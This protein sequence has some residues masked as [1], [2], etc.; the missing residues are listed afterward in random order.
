MTST[1]LQ[2]QTVVV[3]G[4]SSG[5]GLETARQANAAGA[6]VVVSGRDPERLEQAAHEIGALSTATFDATD[7]EQLERFFSGLPT[8]VDHVMV[9]AGGSYYA[10]LPDMNLAEVRRALEEHVLLTLSVARCSIGK[11]RPG[12]SLTFMTGT[13]ARHPVAGLAIAGVL[14]A[15]LPALTMN[16][17]LELAPVRAN[18]I[19]A[20]FVD[21]PLSARLLGD[22]LEMRR[23]VLR[24]TL[25]IRR[26]VDAADV[27]A[28]AL[29]LMTN[30]ALTGATFDIDGGQQLLSEG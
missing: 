19:A 7:Q 21:T 26:V 14:A 15:G 11:V 29:H 3:I 28:L 9:T 16:L 4:G 8:P 18:L 22:D 13:A 2:G 24:R 1:D 6:H 23:A 12:G 17:A 20:G 25:P 10:K 27:A 30:D 5:I